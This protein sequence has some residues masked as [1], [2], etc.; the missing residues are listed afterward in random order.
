MN[1]SQ[2]VSALKHVRLFKGV[3]ARDNLPKTFKK[4]AAFIINT[5]SQKE[6][7]EHWIAIFVSSTNVEYFDPLGFPPFDKHF[8]KFIRKYARK[9]YF[10]NCKTLQNPEST[11]CGKYCVVFIKHRA[12]RGSFKSFIKKFSKNTLHNDKIVKGMIHV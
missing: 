12:C 9:R 10:Y 11:T 4:P 8:L 1:S 3:Y 2:I 6:K 7:G 5:D